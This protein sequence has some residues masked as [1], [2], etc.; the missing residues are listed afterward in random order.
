MHLAQELSADQAIQVLRTTKRLEVT[1]LDLH[2]GTPSERH[3]V[4][5]R[6]DQQMKAINVIK[7]AKDPAVAA[8]LIPFLDYS[9]KDYNLFAPLTPTELPHPEDINLTRKRWPVFSVILDMPGS[10]KVLQ[11]YALDV[12]NPIDLRVTAFFALRYDNEA[13]AFKAVSDKMR[14]EF[15]NAGPKVKD[16]LDSIVNGKLWFSGTPPI[17]ML[18]QMDQGKPGVN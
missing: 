17:V 3:T 12:K 4:E 5:E 10:A 6:Y 11:N 14:E 15:S 1:A 13:A 8:V 16:C 2:F 18:T 7:L 9:A